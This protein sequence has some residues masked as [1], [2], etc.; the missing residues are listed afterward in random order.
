MKRALPILVIAV[1]LGLLVWV[2]SAPRPHPPGLAAH[3][4]LAPGR[5]PQGGDFR[6]DSAGGPVAL[7]DLRGRVVLIY[8]GYTWCPDI[9]PTNLASIARALKQLT[10]AELADVQ[11]LFVTVDPQRD[12]VARLARYAGFFHPNI[13]GL[14]GT[15]VQIAEIATRYGAAFRR[16]VPSDSAMGY[17]VDHSAQT[18]LVDPHGRLRG[19]LDHGAPAAEIVAAIRGLRSSSAP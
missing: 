8:F 4:T 19:T 2:L 5:R 15:E 13:I 12:T 1:L 11:V 14:T 18:Y 9:C 3:K 10:A 16:H 7:S 6:L 17:M